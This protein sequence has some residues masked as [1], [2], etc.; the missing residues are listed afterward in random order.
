M[1]GPPPAAERTPLPR[2]IWKVMAV[3]TIGSFMAQLDA[4]V[5]N[6]SLSSL[7]HALR[8]PFSTVQWTMSGYLLALALLLPLNG[9]LVGRHGVRRVYLGCFGAFTVASVLCGLAWSAPSLIAFRLMQGMCGGLLAPMA[10]LIVARAAGSQMPRVASLV[11]IPILLAPLL[12]PVVA[13][14]ILHVASWR[15][16]FLLNL[17]VGV[18]AF[19]LAFFL[20]PDDR[21][22]ARPR[23]LDLAGLVLLSPGLVLF[24]FGIDHLRQ[25][26]GAP[27]LV[28]ALAAFVLFWWRAR[29][30]G[31]TALIDPGLL[32]LPD[33]SAAMIVL[34]LMNGVSFAGQMLVPAFLIQRGGASPAEAGWL[35]MPLGLGAMSAFPLMGRL[36]DRFGIRRVAVGGAAL[37]LLATLPLVLLGWTGLQPAILAVALFLRGAGSGAIGIPGS[38][39]AYAAVPKHDLPMAATA[40]NIG[41][42]LGGPVLS[43]ICASFLAWR[44]AAAP[45][46]AGTSVAFGEAF[47]LLCIPHALMLLAALRLPHRLARRPGGA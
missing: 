46:D 5:V 2:G 35:L 1:S 21:A 34:F 37:S 17:P 29:R 11:T 13:G 43:T 47:T 42:R 31:R 44:V 12:G 16:L 4:T 26:Y 18:L 28:A 8:A 39:A 3:A 7:S 15:W 14:A 27:M 38:S 10:Q 19:G 40:L 32:R 23:S 6:V 24:L 9:W 25:A 22:D 45:G 30:K 20:L 36:T 41:Q 33:F